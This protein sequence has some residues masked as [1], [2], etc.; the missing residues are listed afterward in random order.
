MCP[1]PR[2]EGKSPQQNGGEIWPALNLV[3]KTSG[4]RDGMGIDT[5]PHRQNAVVE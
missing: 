4:T 3:L 5:S 1:S 2:T